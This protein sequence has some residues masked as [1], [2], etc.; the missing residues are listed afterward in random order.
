MRFHSKIHRIK[1]S[2]G[3]SEHLSCQLPARE[4]ERDV[5]RAAARKRPTTSTR[6]PEASSRVQMLSAHRWYESPRKEKC[7]FPE[8]SIPAIPSKR[9]HG[10]LSMRLALPTERSAVFGS[11]PPT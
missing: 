3:Q 4:Q 5:D 2:F 11:L 10:R 9:R 7:S 8:R 1:L 6:I